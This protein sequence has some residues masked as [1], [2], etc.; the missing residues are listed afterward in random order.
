MRLEFTEY[1]QT[2]G[3]ADTLRRINIVETT[4][5]LVYSGG[6]SILVYQGDQN[7]SQGAATI[8]AFATWWVSIFYAG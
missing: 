5:R 2:T 6:E 4:R 8:M 3:V 7:G 1:S